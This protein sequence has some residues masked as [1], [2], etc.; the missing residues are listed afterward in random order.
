MADVR[1]NGRRLLPLQSV[2]S[3]NDLI[4]KLE[5]VANR[6]SSCLTSILLNGKEIDLENLEA[7]VRSELCAT[8]VV[9]AKIETTAQ[10]AFESLQIAQEM[11]EL[12][13]FDI[14]VATLKLW[15]SSKFAEK[16]IDTLLKDCHS[17]LTLGAHPSDLLQRSPLEMSQTAQDCLR[18]L[19]KIAQSV[20]DAT[21]LAVHG[22]FKD[23]CHVLVGRVM[24]AIE[25][26]LGLTA[27]FAKELEIDRLERPNLGEYAD[28]V[29]F[30]PHAGQV[31]L[32][33]TR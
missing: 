30:R 6:N 2:S 18:E 17:F 7:G 26:W 20:E 10:L 13:T 19:D 23:T 27:A 31:P 11:A 4:D 3:L 25:R 32:N 1:V 5:S 14:K 9:E 28:V 16:E 22:Q 29:T 33:I 15:D 24:P 12:L 8:D 21:L